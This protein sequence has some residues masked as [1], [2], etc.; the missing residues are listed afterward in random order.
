[1]TLERISWAVVVL[2]CAVTA[3]LLAVGGYVGYGGVAAAVGV[4]AA[5]NLR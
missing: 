5:I 4:S 1:M 2:A 3:I